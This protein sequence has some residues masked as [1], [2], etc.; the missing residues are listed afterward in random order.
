MSPRPA[1][2]RRIE[3]SAPAQRTIE[4]ERRADQREVGE[5]LRIIAEGFT[6]VSG[7]LGVEAEVIGEAEHAFEQQ[8]GLIELAVIG[9]AR[10][11]QRL[12]QPEGA[13]VEGAFAT[14]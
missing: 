13:H 4:V 12:D 5:G 14:G 11:G 9:A 7:L 2:T 1:P 3:P 10:T 8:A 6:G